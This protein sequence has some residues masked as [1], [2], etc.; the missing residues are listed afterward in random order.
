[1]MRKK[2]KWNV[3]HCIQWGIANTTLWLFDIIANR[4]ALLHLIDNGHFK[5]QDKEST[6]PAIEK[7][8][9]FR[10]WLIQQFHSY[11]SELCSIAL[12]DDAKIAVA[13]IRTLIEV[14]LSLLSMINHVH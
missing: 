2:V 11:R 3:L 5:A 13:A 14:H 1:M 12:S 8:R 9:V 7:L 6:D 10:K 4:R